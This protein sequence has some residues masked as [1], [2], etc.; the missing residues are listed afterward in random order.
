ME[1]ARK[2]REVLVERNITEEGLRVLIG[3]YASRQHLSP[4]NVG[5]TRDHLKKQ[6]ER[7]KTEMSDTFFV[8]ALEIIGLAKSE[9]AAHQL[10]ENMNTKPEAATE[11]DRLAFEIMERNL[12]TRGVFTLD[13]AVRDKVRASVKEA[14]AEGAKRALMPKTETSI[15]KAIREDAEAFEAQLPPGTNI[16]R[17]AS[18]LHPWGWAYSTDAVQMQFRMFCNRPKT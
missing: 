14:L 17:V 16:T 7:G 11:E 15:Q 6:F 13:V 9:I 2:F 12:G 18:T 4:R 10:G 3:R 1:N 8:K 5:M